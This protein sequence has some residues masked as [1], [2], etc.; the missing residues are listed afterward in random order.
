[1]SG[2]FQADSVYDAGKEDRLVC[3]VEQCVLQ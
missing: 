2:S 1:V 3:H